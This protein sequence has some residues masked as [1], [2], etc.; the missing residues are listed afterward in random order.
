MPLRAETADELRRHV[1][2]VVSQMLPGS[3]AEAVL[4][5]IDQGQGPCGHRFWALDPID[6]T[7]GLL[8]GG[9]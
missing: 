3:D 9:Q 2:D 7:K 4:V 8:R 5:W 1:V 6:G